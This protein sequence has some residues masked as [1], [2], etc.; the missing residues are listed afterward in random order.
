M[1]TADEVLDALANTVAEYSAVEAGLAD[2]RTRLANVK[3]DMTTTEGGKLARAGR[4][5]LVR[6]RGQIEVRRVEVKAPV[7]ERGKLVDAEAARITTAILALEKPIDEQIKADE[8]RR[9]AEAA[10][11]AR[12]A[13]AHKVEYQGRINAIAR[14]PLTLIGATA[15]TIGA[16]IEAMM[17]TKIGEDYGVLIDEGMAARTTALHAM[18]A[19]LIQ[20]DRNEATAA[21]LATA[22]AVAK[23][24]ADTAAAA[25]AAEAATARLSEVAAAAE[26]AFNAPALAPAADAQPMTRRATAEAPAY[27]PSPRP[28]VRP[29]AAAQPSQR[30]PTQTDDEPV[31]MAR[32][33][34]AAPPVA[35]EMIPVP[36]RLLLRIVSDAEH[37]LSTDDRRALLALV[38][39]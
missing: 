3:F 28:A 29:I 17:Q 36:R 30:A 7:L 13:Q 4:L 25:R 35:D 24:L 2:L 26:A 1:S 6:L 31:I 14:T 23:A 16:H 20:A 9:I 10:E 18:D 15:A 37:V 32:R 5:E 22:Q 38:M 19:M 33:P 21:A 8:R 27:A 12:V 11:K 39:A 34:V